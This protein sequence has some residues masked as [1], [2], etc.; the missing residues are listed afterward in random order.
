MK[1]IVLC[2]TAGPRNV[3]SVLRASCNFGPCEIVV[4]APERRALLLHP[5]F[6]QMAHGVEDAAARIRVVE[7]LEEA[8]TDRTQVVGFTG[9]LARH[10]RIEPFAAA[11]E[12][13]LQRCADPAERVALVFGAEA[14]GL[15]TEELERCNQLLFL[16]TSAEHTSLNLSMAVTVVLFS[17]FQPAESR[18]RRA[19]SYPLKAA[20]REHLVADLAQTL[21]RV[22]WTDSAREDI[23]G[24]VERLFGRA[25]LE[26]RDARAWHQILRALGSTYRAVGDERAG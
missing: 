4:V 10:R 2:R 12:D 3:G 26:A 9:R 13:L 17:L 1:R 8:L 15:H 19:R 23:V 20:A 14:D 11:R 5:E 24:A 18:A 22:A 21:G 16:E 6:E 7:T 25:E